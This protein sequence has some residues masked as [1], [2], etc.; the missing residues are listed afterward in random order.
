M[1]LTSKK[2]AKM[3]VCGCGGLKACK[4]VPL[5]FGRGVLRPNRDSYCYHLPFDLEIVHLFTKP[6]EGREGCDT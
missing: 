1:T 5:N 4:V 2:N 3:D 6:L